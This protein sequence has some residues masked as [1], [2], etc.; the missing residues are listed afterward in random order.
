MTW[1]VKPGW[2]HRAFLGE[3]PF[4]EEEFAAKLAEVA[5]ANG[6]GGD[7]AQA[8]ATQTYEQAASGADAARDRP[9]ADPE[10]G[11][12]PAGGGA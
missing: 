9:T 3:G 11:S 2:G 8:R 10:S 5:T 6:W 1:T 12:S 4:G 7:E